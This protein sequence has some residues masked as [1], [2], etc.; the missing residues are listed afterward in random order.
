M[1]FYVTVGET[2]AVYESLEEKF[3]TVLFNVDHELGKIGFCLTQDDRLNEEV[4]NA[5]LAK[6]GIAVP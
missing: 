1:N 3:H 5:I 4:R 2:K 6:G